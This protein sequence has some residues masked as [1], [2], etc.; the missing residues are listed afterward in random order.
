MSRTAITVAAVQTRPVLGAV[1]ANVSATCAR[2]AEAAAHG[3]TLIVLPEAASTGYMFSGPDEA[4]AAAEPVPDGPACRAWARMGAALGV[5]VVAGVIERAA[6]ALYNA[7]VL[8]GPGGHIGTFR[9]VHLWNDEKRLYVP[10]DLGF[11]VFDTGIGRIGLHICYDGWFPESYRLCAVAGADIICVPANWVPVPAQPAGYP[12][13][14][15]L[16][17]MTGAHSNQ[18]YIAAASRVGTERGQAFIGQSIIVDPA[19]VPLA[20]PASPDRE[21]ILYAPADLIG[22][23]SERLA[24]PFNGPLRD[25]RTDLY[26]A[27]LGAADTDGRGS[28]HKDHEE[29]E[30]DGT[31][32]SQ[33]RRAR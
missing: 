22:S 3:A 12:A 28:D 4:A 14:A 32:R 19:G 26:G 18:V 2:I 15:N 11:P 24:N 5:Y 33:D 25:R 21:D 23:R 8:I 31:R 1:P 7:A 16:M 13:M 27:R 9:K 20:G 30:R 6:G 10:G 17:V 29:K